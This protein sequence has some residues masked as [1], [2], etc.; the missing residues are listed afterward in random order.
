MLIV[1]LTGRMGS[2]KDTVFKLLSARHAV[3]RIALAD[4]G[5]R[6]W[7][8]DD[9]HKALPLPDV[10]NMRTLWQLS[11]TEDRE[12]AGVPGLW[13]DFAKWQIVTLNRRLGHDRFV[14]TDM[15]F[16]HEH[17]GFEML[18]LRMGW[19]YEAW[20]VERRES[21]RVEE[22][23]AASAEHVSETSV[24][25][26]VA[27]RVVPNAGTIDDLAAE[28]GKA[29]DAAEDTLAMVMANRKRGKA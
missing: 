19:H 9:A 11:L 3:Q 14:V 15:R 18:A 6:A 27:D 29:W 13:V 16:P 24:D 1:G 10:P 12:A 7:E 28:V 17:H 20:R 23:V 26:I 5:K 25:R 4:P 21:S 8:R 2:G 22:M